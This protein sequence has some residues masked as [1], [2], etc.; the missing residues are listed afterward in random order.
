MRK[1]PCDAGKWQFMVDSINAHHFRTPKCGGMYSE[2]MGSWLSE[3]WRLAEFPESLSLSI[4][5]MHR[6]GTLDSLSLRS[7]HD[8]IK[9]GP[10]D[11]MQVRKLTGS[12]WEMYVSHAQQTD[13]GRLLVRYYKDAFDA[14]YL[15]KINDQTCV[16]Y[17]HDKA[18][19]IWWRQTT[20]FEPED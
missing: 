17:E 16:R 5:D 2:T 6:I 19:D 20:F 12:Y 13:H 14:V 7:T 8:K 11:E 10:P 18:N 1:T 15:Y 3:N 4:D 9:V